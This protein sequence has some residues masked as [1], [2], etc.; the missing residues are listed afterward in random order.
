MR[1]L[2]EIPSQKESRWL[3]VNE[4]IVVGNSSPAQ[5]VANDDSMLAEHFELSVQHDGCWLQSIGD[6]AVAI[7][8]EK[9]SQ[10]RLSDGDSVTAGRTRFA[11]TIEG[12]SKQDE[13]PAETVAPYS[14]R[15]EKP[16]QHLN[17]LRSNDLPSDRNQLLAELLRDTTGFLFVNEKQSG[18]SLSDSLEEADLFKDA[19]D[20]IR[21][22]YSLRLAEF[23]GKDEL[24]GAYDPIRNRDCAVVAYT[25]LS[26]KEV[27][28]AI[29]FHF[30]W[31]S[32][33]STLD[34]HLREGTSQLVEQLLAPFQCI[35]AEAE[36]GSWWI[37]SSGSA[38]PESIGLSIS[39]T[40]EI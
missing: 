39:P 28:E 8:D 23:G 32:Q 38:S 18:L 40:T 36:D 22:N 17:M 1:L 16:N 7:N 34:F 25:T 14:Y 29:Q 37:A 15:M 19:P 24:V 31:Y 10:G 27:L 6:Q 33:P 12:D 35:Y 20:E 9:L 13:L 11:I 21:E 2:I 5:L 26:K 3:R 4:K 30:A